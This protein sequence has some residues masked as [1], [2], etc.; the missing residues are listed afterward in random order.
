MVTRCTP[1]PGG[2]LDIPQVLRNPIDLRSAFGVAGSRPS[3]IVRQGIPV[4]E[5]QYWVGFSLV[6]GVGPVRVRQMLE[7]FGSLKEAWHA[8]QKALRESGL[9]QRSLESLLST[10]REIDPAAE[11]A[12]LDRLGIAALTW[13][14]EEY[15]LLLAQLRPID[16]APPLIYLRGSLA[17][18]DEWAI[19]I[20]GTRSATA[21][22][23]QV[24]HQIAEKLALNGLTIVSGLALG[25][26]AEAH[27]AA[28]ESQQR[29]IA[30]LPCGLD[31]I[32]PPEHRNLVA[33]II[34]Q[35]AVISPFPLGTQPLRTN[36]NARN[37]VLSGLS[38]A[39]AVIEA[40]DKSGALITAGCALD[41]GRQ[42]FA[43]P[44]NITARSSTGTNRL[45]QD[46]AHP[47]LSAQDILEGL[48]LD[49][50]PQQIN[51]AR[52]LPPMSDT[53]QAILESLTAEP[54]HIDELSNHCSLPV[55]TVSSSLVILELKGLVRQVGH[56]IYVRA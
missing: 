53:E 10:R 46:G 47:V 33:R 38:R 41:Q 54:M 56:M 50:L 8:S 40:G 39:V 55:A 1:N 27:L 45:I 17:Q 42:V 19:A 36:F 28:L 43:V 48:A 37:R 24:A 15:P 32:Y 12:R 3:L 35:G 7:T 9:D 44:G 2:Q 29:T 34:Q 25:I 23:R 22:G 20:V 30:V 52:T 26:D 21:Y 11:L 51:A 49:H 14:D 13:D 31:T 6:K 16:Q 4:S 18:T 5:R